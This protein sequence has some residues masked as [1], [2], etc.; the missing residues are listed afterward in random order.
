MLIIVT[1]ASKGI[2]K[3]VAEKFASEGH[4]LL[5]C[6][7][8]AKALYDTVEEIQRKYPGVAIRARIAD[9]GIPGEAIA[10]GEWCLELGIPD[11]LVNNAGFFLPGAIH[12]E[13][14]GT[15]DTMLQANLYSAYHVTRAV[16]P[17]MMKAGR[18]HIFTLCSIASHTAYPNGGSY[19]ISKFALLGFTKN[20]REELKP[21][22]I[23]VTAVSPGATYSA[24]WEG[25]EVD[26]SRMMETADIAALIY[27]AAHLSPAANVEDIIIRPQP[28]DL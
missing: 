5:L 26:R 25:F 20:L 1:G 12:A 27:T 9:L 6:S 7:R 18:G 24:S 8:G 14:A 11:V 22:H 28:G 4:D 23:K 19:G 3:A 2:G 13:S 17:A 15:L 16:L 10:F 21:Y